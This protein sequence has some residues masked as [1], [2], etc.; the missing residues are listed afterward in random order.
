M[1]DDEAPQSAIDERITGRPGYRMSIRKQKRIEETFGWL[2]T[3]AR[4][5]KLCFIGVVQNK[6]WLQMTFAAYNLIR[7]ART[8]QQRAVA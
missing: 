1:A 2:K 5:R 6:L 8:E 7:M 3:V 4:T